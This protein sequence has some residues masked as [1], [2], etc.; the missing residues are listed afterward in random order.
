M[1]A[2]VKY[3]FYPLQLWDLDLTH[4][5]MFAPNQVC[6]EGGPTLRN[7][8]VVL[9]HQVVSPELHEGLGLQPVAWGVVFQDVLLPL[10]TK[11]A[12][13]LQRN[14][15][16]QMQMGRT[17]RLAVNMLTKSLLQSLPI[18]RTLPCFQNIWVSTLVA[19]QNCTDNQSE[20]LAEAVPEN[21]KNLLRCMSHQGVLVPSWTDST[22]DSLWELTW[23]KSQ[24]I[25]TGLTVKVLDG[26]YD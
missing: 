7:H 8:A 10:V 25:S 17:L 2:V 4:L 20:E 5:N 26:A 1:A 12:L 18:L 23:K 3:P 24:Q 19:L 6:V 21:L 16:D 13:L 15:T 9:L 14:G 11:L 22:G